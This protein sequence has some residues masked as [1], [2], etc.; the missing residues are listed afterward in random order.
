[1]LHIKGTAVLDTLQA[2]KARAGKEELDRIISHLD[3][4]TRE[5]FQRPISPSSWYS[6]DAFSRFL[7]ADIRETAGG[8][9]QELVKRAEAVIEKQR[10]L[11]NVRTARLARVRHPPD[12]RR[13]LHL[14]RRRSDHSRNEW[15]Q[16]RGHSVRGISPQASDYGL[17]HSRFFRPSP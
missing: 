2:V 13:S 11:Q 7:E 4:E 15:T 12:C 17:C 6:C 14:F 10:Y 8:N 16:Q 3:P 5:I 1:M 9:E